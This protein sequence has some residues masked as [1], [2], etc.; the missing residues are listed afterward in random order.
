MSKLAIMLLAIVA[1]CAAIACTSPGLTEEEVRSIA[2]EYAGAQGPPGPQGIQGE[3]GEAGPIGP[4]G[5]RGERG[6]E[7]TAGPQGEPGERGP[8]GMPGPKGEQGPEGEKGDVGPSGSPGRQGP[9]GDTGATGPRGPQ[10]PA[11]SSVQ[12]STQ[13]PTATA[14][15]TPTPQAIVSQRSGDWVYFGP[16][17]DDDVEIT[18]A[19]EYD[20]CGLYFDGQF[21]S[22]KAYEDT[23]ESFYEEASIGVSCFRNK[24]F[25]NFSSVGPWLLP[26]DVSV[27]FHLVDQEPG[28]GLYLRTDEGSE[29][30]ESVWFTDRQT[31]DII[32]FL[33][34]TERA[35]KDMTI[36]AVG[37]NTVVA[38]FDVTGFE[39]NYLRLEC[40]N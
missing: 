22:L 10:G 9:K 37:V 34:D 19:D 28:E 25:L 18:G 14:T 12:G 21:I 26:D 36:G 39:T 13:Q 1:V 38:D 2:Q 40:A 5:P 20:N 15:P 6:F 29:D 3:R 11:G 24:P 35:G 23:N 17:C 30:L 8:A 32:A 7:G 16:E 31:R 4:E 33:R 27:N